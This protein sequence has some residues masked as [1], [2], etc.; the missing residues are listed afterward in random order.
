MKENILSKI[1]DNEKIIKE[2]LQNIVNNLPKLLKR[3]QELQVADIKTSIDKIRG[4]INGSN[5]EGR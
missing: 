2:D 1:K 3:Y 5:T 4:N